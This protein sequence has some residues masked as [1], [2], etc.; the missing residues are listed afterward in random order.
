MHAFKFQAIVAPEEL[1]SSLMG[2]AEGKLG[3]WKLWRLWSEDLERVARTTWESQRPLCAWGSGICRWLWGNGTQQ[4]SPRRAADGGSAMSR[5]KISVELIFGLTLQRWTSNGFKDPLKCES[6]RVAAFYIMSVWL[7]NI[8]TCL[9]GRNEVSDV[10]GSKPPC[11]ADY[12]RV[13][14]DADDAEDAVDG[15]EM[16]E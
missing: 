10:F 15:G 5:V 9:D 1:V 6:S 16:V 7:T 12:L 11:L 14:E 13:E 2:P 8:K 3:D 4:T